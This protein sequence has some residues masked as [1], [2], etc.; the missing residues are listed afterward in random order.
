MSGTTEFKLAEDYPSNIYSKKMKW[1]DSNLP[2]YVL[3]YVHLS[4]L[5]T[6]QTLMN[7][8]FFLFCSFI[9]L[10]RKLCLR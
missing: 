9:N 10:R 2:S 5:I 1:T 6:V 3:R 7:F 4:A 8:S